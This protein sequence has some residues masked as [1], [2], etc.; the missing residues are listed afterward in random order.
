MARVLLPHGDEACLN[1]IPLAGSQGR[2]E[3]FWLG[4]LVQHRGKLV[5]DL[6]K[7]SVS[8]HLERSTYNNTE[9]I[10]NLLRSLGFDVAR[11]STEFPVIEEMIKRRHQIVHRADR[12]AAAETAALKPITPAEVRGWSAATQEFIESLHMPLLK[13]LLDLRERERHLNT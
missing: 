3:K 1:E 2:K 13:K 11:H 12:F 7:E 8:E 6:L 5:D 4:R 9:E 10:A